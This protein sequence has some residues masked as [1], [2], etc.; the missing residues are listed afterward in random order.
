MRSATAIALFALLSLAA[1]PARAADEPEVVYGK[2]HRAVMAG[3]L[4][5]MLKHGPAQ[6]RS[7]MRGLSESHR[8]AA[9]KMARFMMPR[10]FSLQ[11]KSVSPKGRA[12]L[13]VSGPGDLGQQKMGTIYGTIELMLEGGEWK[14][15]ESNWSSEKPANLAAA[16]ADKPAAKSAPATKSAAPAAGAPMVGTMAPPQ[17]VRPLGKA[18]PP[19]VY[20]AVMTAEDLE[21]CK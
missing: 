3:D 16:P 10:A 15:D 13:I 19:C 5:E 4:E 9:L 12:T 7:E 21:N 18:K 8:E 17:P 14:V 1:A 20:K 6:R 11:K 2:Y